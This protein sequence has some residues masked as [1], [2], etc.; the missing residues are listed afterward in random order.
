VFNLF[1]RANYRDVQN[2][3]DSPRFGEFFNGAAR[4]FHGKFVLEF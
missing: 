3:L 1:N 4:T 2:N